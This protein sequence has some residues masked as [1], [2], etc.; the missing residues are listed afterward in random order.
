MAINAHGAHRPLPSSEGY[1]EVQQKVVCQR[2]QAI[3]FQNIL[4][5]S[6]SVHLHQ[7]Q[8]GKRQV[9][10]TGP[11]LVIVPVSNQ[12][13]TKIM[14][15]AVCRKKGRILTI[16]PCCMVISAGYRSIKTI[17]YLHF[18]LRWVGPSFLYSLSICCFCLF[19]LFF[20]KWIESCL[21]AILIYMPQFLPAH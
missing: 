10:L 3:P 11:L 9:L 14:W 1:S 5:F 4:A 8:G 7:C 16:G 21:R 12:L 19:R 13:I 20:D 6:I 17:S 18:I 2:L 15:F